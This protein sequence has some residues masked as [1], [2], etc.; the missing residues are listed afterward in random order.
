M[1]KI[2]ASRNVLLC[3]GKSYLNLDSYSDSDPIFDNEFYKY[4][5][6]TH[7]ACYTSEEIHQMGIFGEGVEPVD[8]YTNKDWFYV[9]NG[10]E[11]DEK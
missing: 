1:R 11:F 5:E 4:D 9:E 7:I 10:Y 2:L 6:G 3:E 8:Y